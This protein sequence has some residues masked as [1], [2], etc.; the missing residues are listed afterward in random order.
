MLLCQLRQATSTQRFRELSASLAKLLEEGSDLHRNI[1]T[2]YLFSYV[3]YVYAGRLFTLRH[4][5]L[6]TTNQG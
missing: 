6:L 1:F 2:S 4:H 3:D 5:S